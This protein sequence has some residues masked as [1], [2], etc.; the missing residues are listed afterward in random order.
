MSCSHDI[1]LATLPVE[2]SKQMNSQRNKFSPSISL[3]SWKG[4]QKFLA[5][6]TEKCFWAT[7]GNASSTGDYLGGAM[8]AGLPFI[9]I[10]DLDQ[11]SSPLGHVIFWSWWSRWRPFLRQNAS[12][13][14]ELGEVWNTH[15]RTFIHCGFSC[16]FL[17]VFNDF[18]H[19]YYSKMIK[20]WHIGSHILIILLKS[21]IHIRKSTL[22]LMSFLKLINKKYISAFISVNEPKLSN[23]ECL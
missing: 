2:K 11:K 22:K 3:R 12:G 1:K 9:L 4:W 19:N 13:A 15:F 18:P 8:R 14:N 5:F 20:L 7:K 23:G 17:F 21:P 6:L 10:Q 16:C